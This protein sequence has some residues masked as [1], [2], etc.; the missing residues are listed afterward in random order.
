MIDFDSHIYCTLFS[1]TCAFSSIYSKTVT[2]LENKIA[3]TVKGIHLRATLERR[4]FISLFYPLF[5][6]VRHHDLC[7]LYT[8]ISSDLS[9]RLLSK[10]IS[11]MGKNIKISRS[12]RQNVVYRQCYRMCSIIVV[13]MLTLL[14][15]K[16]RK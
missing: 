6:T 9:H 16:T 11:N 12:E 3:V 5:S 10:S 8:P 7:P 1:I 2:H 4:G 13:T 14:F 15:L